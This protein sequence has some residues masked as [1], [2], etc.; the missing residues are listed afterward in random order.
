M[1]ASMAVSAYEHDR[2]VITRD[3]QAGGYLAHYEGPHAAAIE[4]AF[5]TATLPTAYTLRA[6]RADV[7]DAIRARYPGVIVIAEC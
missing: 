1:T 3:H 6:R 5:G 7:L 2:I 4:R